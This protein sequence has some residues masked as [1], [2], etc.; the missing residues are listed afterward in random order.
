MTEESS[1]ES[2]YQEF[3]TPSKSQH[4]DEYE[5]SG[6]YETECDSEELDWDAHEEVPSYI[7]ATVQEEPRV[8]S[9]P[10][11]PHPH[12]PN[13]PWIFCDNPDPADPYSVWPVRRLSSDNN[14]QLIINL[15][16]QPETLRDH[17]DSLEDEVFAESDLE[18][19]D[20]E[21]AVNMPPRVITD[22]ELVT[23]F[24]GDLGDWKEIL[25]DA[26]DADEVPDIVYQDITNT[27]TLMRDTVKVLSRRAQINLATNFPEIKASMSQVRK[28]LVWIDSKRKK[29]NVEG[30][31]DDAANNDDK[32]D[33]EIAK[34][35]VWFDL[36]DEKLGLKH[37]ALTQKLVKPDGSKVEANETLTMEMKSEKAALDLM[38]DKAETAQLQVTQASLKYSSH[39]K[40][41]A[42]LDLLKTRMRK[43][44][45]DIEPV[46]T[47][48]IG[49][50]SG[51]P[52]TASG[53][54]T[55]H[56]PA[57][58]TQQQTS[59]AHS[60]LQRL[61]LP[62]FSGDSTDY[63]HFKGEFTRQASYEEDGDKVIAL[64]ESMTK[65][66]DKARISK[67]KTLAACWEKLDAEYG[68]VVT[69]AT[70]C[71]SIIDSLTLHSSDQSFV[72][73]IDKV[74][75]CIA[76]LES[77]P[78]GKTYVPTLML[79]VERKLDKD[80][81]KELS[82]KLVDEEP[83]LEN[84]PGF[85]MKFLLKRKKSAKLR[86][87]QYQSHDTK[88]DP[89][90]KVKE[91]TKS[92]ATGVGTEETPRG[93]GGKP[94]GRGSG[95]RG[96]GGG[97]DKRGRG[98]TGGRGRGGRGANREGR[99]FN[100]HLCQEDH[101]T[102]NCPKWQDTNT[103]KY[104]LHFLATSKNICTYCLK[105][106]H[107]AKDCFST[108]DFGCPCGSE[109]NYLICPNTQ[110]CQKR[111]N[112]NKTSGNTVSLN[113]SSTIVNGA[114]VGATLNP[115]V[116][117]QILGSDVSLPTMFDNC[118]QTT[119]ILNSVARENKL[120]GR[121]ISFVLVCT[122]GSKSK[123]IGKL[124]QVSLRDIDGNT[125]QI[126]AIGLDKISSKFSGA[127]VTN[128][129]RDLFRHRECYTLQDRKLDRKGGD[130]KMLIGTD[131][132]SIHPVKVANLGDLIIMKTIFG[133]GWTM[134]GHSKKHVQL[135]ESG[136][137]VKVHVTAVES[138][139]EVGANVVTTKDLQFLEAV[140]TDSLGIDVTPKCRTCKIRSEKC[141]E[142]KMI[143]NNKTYLEHLQDV[144]IDQNIE[145]NKDGPGYIASY[146]YN[147]EL[148][149]LLP[150]EEVCIKR[151]EAV[152]KKMMMNA[153]DLES[154]NKEIKKSFDNGAFRF[155]SDQ[156]LEEW[157]GPVHHLAM[158]VS[159]KDSET[160]PVRLCYD[161]SQPDRNGRTLNDCMSK[162]S[163]PI[164]H[165]GAVILNFR[166]AEQ[167]G[168]GDVTKMFQQ[169][170]VRPIDMHLR[171]FHMRP[172][173][174]GGKKPWRIAVPTCVNFGETA[175][176]AVATRVKNRAADD[177]REISPEVADMIK[178]DC[179]MDD[180]NINCKYK[181]NLDEKIEKAE[182]ILGKGNFSIKKWMK[183]GDKGEK[184]LN[185][186]ELSKSLGL[187]W[188][189]ER[190]ILSYRIKLNFHK[191]K[192]NRYLGPYTTL[193]TLDDDFPSPVT[194]RLALKLN[195][196]VFD[197]QNVVQPFIL[198]P[199]LAFR[200]I[201]IYEREAGKPGWDNPLPEKFRDEWLK[202]TKEMFHL[203]KLE[204]PRSLVPRNYDENVKPTLVL[205]SDGSDLAQSV[206]SY[207]VWAMADGS[208]HVSLVTSRAK[209]AS[210]TKIST[211]KS[212]LCAAQMSSRLR[213]WLQSE[214]D[215]VTGEVFHFVD[216]S[217]I[218]GMLKNISLKFD[219]YTAPRITEIQ[220]N[221][222]VEDWYWVDTSENPAD[223]STRGKCTVEDLGPGTMWREGP[224]WLKGPRENWKV[225][226]DFKKHEMPGLKKEFDILP[227]TISNVTQ[228]VNFHEVVMTREPEVA[229]NTA[230]TVEDSDDILDLSRFN[231]WSKLCRVVAQ[232][233]K[234]R[235]LYLKQKVP[236]KVD[237]MKEAKRSLLLS[238]MP[239]TREMLKTTKLSGFLIHEKDGLILAT[240]RN[241]NENLNPDD[242][243]ILSPKHPIT[244]MILQTIHNI[245]HRGV[246]YCVARSRIFYWIPQASKL[247][248]SIKNN[249]YTCKLQDAAALTQLMAP[250]P[251]FRLKASPCWFYT[252]LDLFGPIEVVN[253][254]NQRTK[255][256]TWAVILTCL[257]SRCCWVYLAESY[258]TDHLLSVLRKH[259]SRNGSPAEY[260]ADLGR[261]IVGADRAL[262]EQVK[263]LD[264]NQIENFSANRNVKFTFGIPH[265]HEG[266]GAVERLVA[267]V[268]KNLKVITKNLLTF[269]EL[270]TLLS[271][272]S[273]L[274]NSRPLQPYP[275][276][277]ED[278]F[279]CP[280]D[281]L[282]GRSDRD[283]PLADFDDTSL[284]RKAAHK[285][286]IIEEFWSKWSTSYYQTLYRFTKWRLKSRNMQPGDVALV[287]D[288][289]VRKGKF[290][291]A[292]V[293]TAKEDTDKYVRKVTL[294]YRTP[295]K[296]DAEEYK[297][298]VFKYTERNVRG[299]ALLVTAEERK[300]SENINLDDIRLSTKQRKLEDIPED[301]DAEV[302]SL[303]DTSNEV[304]IDD[305]TPK[306]S[307]KKPAHK[308]LTPSSSGRLR[309]QAQKFSS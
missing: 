106:G 300:N 177:Y 309:W 270:D 96:R 49:Y 218:I 34:L 283:P 231:C 83:T 151:A 206:V 294:K 134:M 286:R 166:A 147:N 89:P 6:E 121:N 135:T 93:R 232:V 64:R 209:I 139:Q 253:F 117:V 195:H 44:T 86:L 168:C 41:Q 183:S 156:E 269:G 3:A 23:K 118:S 33:E 229:A 9:T 243:V 102:S 15:V 124:F 244:K 304:K 65:K 1:D 128:V 7:E 184:E 144:Q 235:Y 162:G 301:D 257:T 143:T 256:K 131:V 85:V 27:Y 59:S 172:D 292:I 173:F 214:M 57:A 24:N 48:V 80:L 37:T 119:F 267:E 222:E 152:E 157:D 76:S 228:L 299:L 290:T 226:S 75:D 55:V 145:R 62:K 175:A 77:V 20:Q 287:L 81:Q 104:E 289:E 133:T 187:W 215:I 72:D 114:R 13:L 101:Q 142:C 238:M 200:D 274:V 181:E 202:L 84:K 29:A 255:R 129:K 182:L 120:R 107:R 241:K 305:Q 296:C 125:H 153:S 141:K 2:I 198:K 122:D 16:P 302:E 176:P 225:R 30:E 174:L 260:M 207:L 307:V 127:K 281:I 38:K 47:L 204:F 259:E 46:F 98:Q 169:V 39:E 261:Q 43:T 26:Q 10:V 258:S 94:A 264:Q 67:E 237:L 73:F 95:D 42:A 51:I 249:C 193:E 224:D 233:L 180:I 123:K 88:K 148:S 276:L 179:I 126:Q 66:A 35:N 103:S 298:T 108:E 213:V 60:K 136:A 236:D 171:R 25:A 285:Q 178:K 250:L 223:L 161:S 190:D 52:D 78:S 130:I 164:N 54:I 263:D 36:A 234:F 160:T 71:T 113:T 17:G 154:I 22:D 61:P 4:G 138:I 211:P 91:E 8:E 40:K 279:I 272:A 191:K 262:S 208:Y 63:L 242:L 265:F 140:S 163:N 12:H 251:Q 188:H 284:T 70:E 216:A 100:C 271:E 246:Q 221:T 291:P 5:A 297:P 110:E 14:N 68:D 275:T 219:T 97:R 137:D 199:R 53:P 308:P 203:E 197:P 196:S 19:S 50:L 295:Q 165:F 92:H 186:S 273:Y 11:Q 159:Y 116:H 266:Q 155:L 150:N 115:I 21:Q 254:V 105:S 45:R 82:N 247:M 87:K 282:F 18:L 170:K 288:K 217:I 69:L 227:S 194:K 212:E 303:D 189:T 205:F 245:N 167:V 293:A 109:I 28:D 280:N 158:N 220:M 185:K 240:T 210:M 90:K 31:A 239:A 74:E 277:G 146:P 230:N 248:K 56:V 79:T 32:V 132:A 149:H 252:M 58:Q 306:S 201:L 268:K 192:R 112:W 99:N 111:S 278:A